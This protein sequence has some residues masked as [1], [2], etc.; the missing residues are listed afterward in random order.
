MLSEVHSKLRSAGLMARPSAD[1]T[2]R[3]GALR[4]TGASVDPLYLQ[5]LSA[6]VPGE[7]AYAV[8]WCAEAI[9]LLQRN[10]GCRPASR[11]ASPSDRFWREARVITL[12]GAPNLGALAENYGHLMATEAIRRHHHRLPLR[13]GAPSKA[14]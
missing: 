13:A 8:K 14:R 9:E 10:S 5:R 12:H 11:K 7:T 2:D 6:S 3:I 4:S 1:E